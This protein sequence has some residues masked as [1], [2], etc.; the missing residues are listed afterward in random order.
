MTPAYLRLREIREERGLTQ[1]QL[2][3]LSGIP[4]QTLSRLE[5]GTTR[6]VDLDMLD[7]LAK[8]LNVKPKD[9]IGEE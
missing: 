3:Y 4:Q 6:V 1:V 2:F 8:A 5:T 7:L 9:L